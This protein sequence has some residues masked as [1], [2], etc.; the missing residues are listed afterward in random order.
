[1]RDADAIEARL[2]Q[3]GQERRA[4]LSHPSSNVVTP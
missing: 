1:V 3:Q 2:E 4:K